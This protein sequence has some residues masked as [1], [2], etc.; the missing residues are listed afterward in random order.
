MPASSA[1]PG[2]DRLIATC[3]QRSIPLKLSPPVDLAP[4][5]G[6]RVLGEP[7]D[8]Q[9]AATYQRM[10]AS[11]LGPLTLYGLG[12]GREGL[13]PRNEWLRHDDTVQFHSALV[14]GWETGFAYYYGTVPRLAN[15]QGLQPVVYIDDYEAK[16]AVPVASSVDRFFEIY[17]RYLE[18]MAVDP[19]YIHTGV[20][21]INFPW[22]MAQT[23]ARDEPLMEQ[24]LA[25]RFDFLT[26]NEPDAQEWLQQLRAARP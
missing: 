11:E 3:Q 18:L 13:L 25:D 22:A 8:P 15:S 6:E 20:T 17:S 14:F 24:V 7:F 23:V 2:L 4:K 10:G 5:P 19:E 9:L 12:S 21:R 1:L 26:H 16:Y